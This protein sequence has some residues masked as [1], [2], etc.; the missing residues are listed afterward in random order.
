MLIVDMLLKKAMKGELNLM[1]PAQAVQKEL[2]SIPDFGEQDDSLLAAEG[3]YVSNFKKAILMTAGA[4]VQTFMQ[5]LGK[6]QEILMNISD[7][8][9]ETYVA[10]SMLLRVKKLILKVGKEDAKLQVAMA[11]SYIY[12]AADK[13]NKSGKDAIN[14]LAEGDE[15]RMMLLG[16]KRFTKVTPF[17]IKEARQ[18][19]AKKL[20]SEN[21]YV[22]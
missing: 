21:K 15:Q 16:I 8:I 20:I 1:G 4:A 10:E 2:M 17:N 3:R 18:E 9:I 13:I 6:E 11:Q 12:D 22:F 7:M 14:S 19:I 5:N